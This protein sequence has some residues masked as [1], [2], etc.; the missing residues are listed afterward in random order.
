MAMRRRTFIAALGSAAVWPVV[1]RA[2][3][4][5]RRPVVG[6][7][8]P[9]PLEVA[10][11]YIAAVRTRLAELGHVEGRNYELAVRNAPLPNR[12]AA[13]RLGAELLTLSP[14]VIVMGSPKPMILAI[15]ELTSSVPV[16]M[17]NLNE[18]PVAL[19]LAASI[20]RPGG[21][22][23]GFMLSSDRAIV[24]K[25]LELLRELTPSIGRVEAL[26]E[27]L[28]VA[29][30]RLVQEAAR[31]LNISIRTFFIARGEEI[32]PIIAGAEGNADGYLF[33]A[34]P[35]FNTTRH[36]IVTLVARTRLPAVYHDR[37]LVVA[38]G[39][40]S[41]GSSIRKNY[42]AAAEYVAKILGGAKPGDLPIQ[43]PAIYDL[44]INLKTAKTLGLTIPPTLL[45][46]AD[47]VIE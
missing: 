40:M 22:M 39:L 6:F 45:A 26:F 19:G 1:A 23:T 5:E 38:G 47:E 8:S 2:Q 14:A 30:E 15:H 42:A 29:S 46:R 16:V 43:Q 33:G 12:E 20:A 17:V 41:Y 13:L 10:Q 9:T 24:G 21:N 37:E 27:A 11:P 7:L 25:Q 44:V 4:T 36:D 31:N 34:G 3:R 32:A 28:D 35:L 18:D